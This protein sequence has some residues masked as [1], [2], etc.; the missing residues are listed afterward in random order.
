MALCKKQILQSKAGADAVKFQ[1]FTSSGLFS[2]AAFSGKGLKK[3]V[4]K[5][6]LNIAKLKRDPQV[7]QKNKD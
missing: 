1:M 2:S 5:F 4:D 3:D 7:L 6:S